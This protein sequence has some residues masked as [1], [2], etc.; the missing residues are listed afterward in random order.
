MPAEARWSGRRLGARRPVPAGARDRSDAGRRAHAAVAPGAPLAFASMADER[1]W[2]GRRLHLIGLGGAGMSGYARV[3]A[4]LGAAV[5]GSDRA[6]SPGLRALVDLG[7]EVHVGHDAAN[8][9][10]GEGVEVVHSTAIAPDNP[11]RAAARERGLP[12]HPRAELLGAAE[13]AQAH[14]RD[15]RRARQDHDDVDGGARAAA[16]RPRAVLPHRRGADDDRAQRRLGRGGVARGRGRRVG[17]LDALA[18]RRR[19]RRHQRRARPPRHL[20]VAG[21]GARRLPRVA[22][23]RAAGR[24]VGAPRRRR[25]ARRRAVR[26][27][28]RRRARRS[29]ATARASTGA[30]SACACSVPGAHNARNA[31]AALEACVAGRRRPRAGRRGAGRLHRRRAPLPGAGDHERRRTRRRRL[32]PS[33]D[34]G[35]GHHRGRPHA[36]AAPR[37]GGLP[38]APVLAHR[39]ASRA[40]S[41]PRWPAPTSRPCSTSTRRASAPRT[42]PASAGCLVAEADRG[43]RRRAHGAVA[44]DL[45]RRRAGA[46]GSAARR[47]TCAWCSARGTWTSWGAGWSLR[48]E[49]IRLRL[50]R[51]AALKHHRGEADP[52]R[53]HRAGPPAVGYPGPS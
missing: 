16:L 24:P 15:R 48:A 40:S 6:D 10:A 8:V 35:R 44:A 25:P 41:A 2:A 37:G 14:D 52:G 18:A 46:A 1:P 13:R 42:S 32:R 26:G 22:G 51:C 50:R 36:G 28:R 17:P 53:R 38:A 11:E 34:R 21:R 19:R 45:R 3:A 43:R 20:R 9:P 27:L 5:S 7:V 31:A 30:G 23:R 39:S 33:P 47:A 12:D 49:V 29:T 4:Q